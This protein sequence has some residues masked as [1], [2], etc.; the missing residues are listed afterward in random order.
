MDFEAAFYAY[1]FLQIGWII[2]SAIWLWRKQDELPLI[3]SLFLFYVFAF[4][5]WALLQGWTAPV[6][7]SPLGFAP[8]Q[9]EHCLTS[10]GLAVLGQTVLLTVYMLVQKRVILVPRTLASGPFLEWLR[11]RTFLFVL[12]CAT[13]SIL[14]RRAVGAQI[15]EGKSMSF[16]IS[17][18]LSLFPMVLISAG[19]L[20]VLLWRAGD[21]HHGVHKLIFVAMLATVALLTFNTS[22]RFQFLGWIMAAIVIFTTGLP[23]KRK[24]LLMLAGLVVAAALFAVAGAL[25]GADNP[26]FELQEN[27]VDRFAFAYDANMLDGFVLLRQVYPDMLNYTY[28][29]EHLEILTRPIPRAWWPNKPVGGYLN[30]L[31][32]IDA[33]SGFS[34]G[35]SPSL[36][37]SFY[38]EGGF[39]AVI[40]LSAIYGFGFGRLIRFA[41]EIHPFG[42]TLIRAITCAAVLP[43][44]RGG[45]LPGI[46]AWFGMAFWPCFLLLWIWRKELLAKVASSQVTVPTPWHPLVFASPRPHL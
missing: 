20:L 35:I 24:A 42:G 44:L 46:Y 13:L 1:A 2:A 6:N 27:S 8:V 5:F 34:L 31:G 3:L 23:V 32:L 43:L 38:Q 18:Y 14:T 39:I 25:R 17:S 12:V 28:G 19:I 9:V 26:E 16:E 30:K 15:L 21:L 33:N 41:A 7:I 22:S 29:G 40:L 11:P 4:R 45:D 37:G 36:F 10:D